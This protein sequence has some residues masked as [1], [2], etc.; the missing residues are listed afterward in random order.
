MKT[1]IAMLSIMLIVVGLGCAALSSYVTPA[2]VDQNALQYA[3]NAGVAE[4]SDYNAWYPN[5]AEAERLAGDVDSAHNT[6]QLSLRQQAQKDDLDYSIHKGV[7]STNL[8]TAN[9]REEMLFGET[10]LMS[11]GLSMAGFGGLT[12]LLGLMRKRPGDITKPEM[13]QALA[14]ATGKTTEELSLKQKQMIQL[15]KGVQAFMDHPVT[16]QSPV[17]IET[18]K[19][20]MNKHQDKDTQAAVAVIKKTV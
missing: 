2:E 16:A 5:L 14:T 15:V 20:M 19:A 12:G 1:V 17:E 7:V 8:V 13:E 3:I 4:L 18:L 10:G 9:Q 11:L 6:V